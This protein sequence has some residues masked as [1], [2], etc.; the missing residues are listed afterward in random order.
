MKMSHTSL[1]RI[2]GIFI[3]IA[4]PS[5]P[6]REAFVQS[7]SAPKSA[8]E[9]SD[10]SAAASETTSGIMALPPAQ[11]LPYACMLLATGSCAGFMS[12]L[13]GIGGGILVTPLLALSSDMPQHSIVGTSMVAMVLPAAASLYTHHTLGN[14]KW[15]VGR[16][17]LVGSAVGAAVGVTIAQ[18]LDDASMKKFFAVAMFALGLKTLKS[19]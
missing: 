18:R 4:A 1:K 6:L 15:Q 7:S 5:V 12:G 10:Q 19:A 17:L 3:L 8:E 9:G 2:M 16:M 13:L 14:V 11:Q